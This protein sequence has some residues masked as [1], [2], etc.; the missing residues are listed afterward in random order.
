MSPSDDSSYDRSLDSN[1][2]TAPVKKKYTRR[3]LLPRSKNGCWILCASCFKFGI[4]CDYNPVK[5]DY[6]TDKNLRK[7][8]LID[9]TTTRKKQASICGGTKSKKSKSAN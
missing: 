9:I 6:V 1:E 8:K 7:Q 5:P 3:R 2:S 4:E